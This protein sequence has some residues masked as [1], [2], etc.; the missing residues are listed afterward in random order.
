MLPAIPVE[1]ADGGTVI[2]AE[3]SGKEALETSA[4]WDDL[5]GFLLQRLKDEGQAD[6][7]SKV[8]KESWEAHRPKA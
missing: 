8:F 4:F 6:E 5:R 2:E 7:L 1:A 3:P